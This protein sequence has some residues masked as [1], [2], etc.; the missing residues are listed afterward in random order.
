MDGDCL[1][2]GIDPWWSSIPDVPLTLFRLHSPSCQEERRKCPHHRIWG[3]IKW[4]ITPKTRTE[5]LL[6]KYL[7]YFLIYFFLFGMSWFICSAHQWSQI[8]LSKISATM[9]LI[10][11]DIQQHPEKGCL[12][13]AHTINTSSPSIIFVIKFYRLVYHIVTGTRFCFAFYFVVL[14]FSYKQ[15]N[16]E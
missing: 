16:P 9:P 8:L 4:D 13:V 15:G 3:L 1:G 12:P 5:E 14:F 2:F 6:S 10:L 11:Y 7:L